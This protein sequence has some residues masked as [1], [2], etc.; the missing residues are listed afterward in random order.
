MGDNDRGNLNSELYVRYFFTD[1][2]AVKIGLQNL[3]T[4]Y[5][6]NSKVQQFPES[7]DRFRNKSMLMSLGIS[8]S[9]N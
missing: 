1:A 6:T 7:N 5:T 2:W 9:F 4:E 8:H 3:F